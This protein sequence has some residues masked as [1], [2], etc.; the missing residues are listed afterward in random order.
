MNRL[1]DR[2]QM[3]A[4]DAC[5]PWTGYCRPSGHGQISVNRGRLEGTHRLAWMLANGTDV[6]PRMYVCHHCD[7]PPCC[8]PAHLYVGTPKDNSQD[9]VDR[10]RSRGPRGLDNGNGRLTPEQVEMVRAEYIREYRRY[11]GGW[12]SNAAELAAQVGCSKQYIATIVRGEWR[13]HG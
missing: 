12:R 2:V 9:A 1:W 8:N 6:P 5:W 3:G 13:A 7:N 11:R 4:E 10:G